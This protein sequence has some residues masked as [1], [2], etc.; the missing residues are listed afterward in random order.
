MIYFKEAR[1]KRL[2]L[3]EKPEQIHEILEKGKQQ[4]KKRAQTTLNLVKEKTGLT[5]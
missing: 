5:L 4:A 1:E 3:I 2:K